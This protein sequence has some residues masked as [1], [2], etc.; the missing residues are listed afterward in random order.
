MRHLYYLTPDERIQAGK[1]S[2]ISQPF[3][4][5]G[6]ATGKVSVGI[7]LLRVIGSTSTFWRKWI[8]C[9]AVVTAFLASAV[10]VILTFA[11]CSPAEALWNPQ[12]VVEGK[13]K[14]WPPS[15]Q[16]NFAIFVSS[17]PACA[18]IL[19]FP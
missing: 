2:W 10:N 14:C 17:K 11:Q 3:V 5:M 1:W 15:I 18:C 13:A 9:F 16:T 19:S 6:F 7:L 4:I 12:L 8:L